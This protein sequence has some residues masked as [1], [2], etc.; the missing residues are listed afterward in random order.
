MKKILLDTNF[1]LIPA[2][3]KVDIFAEM[4]RIIEEA[5][6]VCVLDKTVDELN[7]IREKQTVRYRKAAQLALKLIEA[8]HIKVIK[9]ESIKNVDEIIL[10]EADSKFFI[11]ATQDG[12]LKRKLRTKQVPVIVLRQK[13]HLILT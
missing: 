11:V 9:T 12:A 3:L 13:K 6:E 1:L 2:M 5:Y 8:M 10:E 4:E 7:S